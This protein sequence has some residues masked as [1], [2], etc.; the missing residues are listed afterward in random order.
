MATIKD[1]ARLAGVG[2]GT[3][4]R[5]INGGEK[6]KASTLEKV[7]EAAESLNYRPNRTA[8]S[9]VMGLEETV[10]L[11]VVLP[12]GNRSLHFE[13]LKGIHTYIMEN[14]CNLMIFSLGTDRKTAF[15]R[16][17][18]SSIHGLLALDLVL[19]E[20][21]EKALK[22]ARIPYV[23]LDNDV[24]L[25]S[26]IHIN[27]RLGGVIAA[28]HLISRGCKKVAYVGA[29]PA[30][31]SQKEQL[32]GFKKELN[33]K[34]I[35]LEME[36]YAPLGDIFGYN[37]TRKILTETEVD[38][39]FFSSDEFA[40][41]A[42]RVF[43]EAGVGLAIIGYGDLPTSRILALSSVRQPSHNLGF[44]G[45]AILVELI[46]E[47]SMEHILKRELQPEYMPRKS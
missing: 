32:H 30:P 8:R 24:P 39:I 14:T 31:Q 6:V 46:Q 47:G 15:Q 42:F 27:N 7:L 36:I 22:M 40:F 2:I 11:G 38:G 28:E 9:L 25:Q 26:S 4:S 17:L 45:C 16:I 18:K 44:E 29:D 3:V 21:E 35:N 12:A 33:D 37:E 23:Y 41:G 10:T 5:V 20:P 13:I 1:I 43:R 19:T 34:G